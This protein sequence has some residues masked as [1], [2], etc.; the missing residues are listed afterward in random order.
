AG[1]EVLRNIVPSLCL[2]RCH[3]WADALRQPSRV[4]AGPL[5]VEQG[6]KVREAA[7]PERGAPVIVIEL[8]RVHVAPYVLFFVWEPVVIAG[9]RPGLCDEQGARSLGSSV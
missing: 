9:L 3:H 6:V 5:R 1:D 7:G 4:Q 8:R 2:D